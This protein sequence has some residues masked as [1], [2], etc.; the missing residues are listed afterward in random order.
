MRR[1]ALNFRK[2]V[3][4]VIGLPNLF[5]GGVAAS[6]STASALATKLG[7]SESDIS[8]F[9][10]SGNDVEA[11][12]EIDYVLPEDCFLDSTQITSFVDLQHCKGI[13]YRSLYQCINLQKVEIVNCLYVANFAIRRSTALTEILLQSC[14][15]VQGTRAF[16][17]L[18]N[19][20]FCYLPVV[21]SLG[22]TVGNDNVFQFSKTSAKILINK[23]L[24]TSN[25]GA[26]DGDLVSMSN[27]VYIDNY[28]PPDAISDLTV[29][30]KY[31]TALQ[32]N[33]TPPASVNTV[34]FYQV[35]IN[36]FYHSD[37]GSPGD[38]IFGLSPN[39]AYSD[40]TVKAVDALYNKSS[41]SNSVSATTTSSYIDDGAV[42]IFSFRR[43]RSSA[44]YAAKISRSSD[45]AE[46]DV[47]LPAENGNFIS[48]S[49]MVSSGGTLGSWVGANDAV[50]KTVYGQKG[51]KN[52]S[53][54]NAD[55]KLVIAGVLNTINGKPAIV[56]NTTTGHGLEAL[57]V[58]A[59]SP[60]TDASIFAVIRNNDT[61]VTNRAVGFGNYA[62][63][64]I[65]SKT[66]WNC[67]ADNSLRFDGAAINTPLVTAAVGNKIRSSF[68]NGDTYSDYINGVQNIVPTVLSGTSIVDDFYVG[69]HN[70][71][72]FYFSEAIVFLSDESA[73]RVLIENEINAAY[74]IY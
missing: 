3:S 17:V 26:P 11:S 4:P 40:I 22:E 30:T 73:D 5:I 10:V 47:L 51:F 19:L 38:F 63:D 31:A 67:A 15:N 48:M 70:T 50:V 43:R 42:E 25:S 65:A 8:L 29:G 45:N 24:E 53:Y 27:V 32:L 69:I 6:I 55:Y 23:F 39:S 74:S 41:F 12:I 64:G 68:K 66:H 37:L 44:V 1:R 57:G 28:T 21:T 9:Q 13:E 46:T 56:G 72:N 18:S 52:L 60:L 61:V 33:F 34:E 54:T 2:H 14:T 36:G 71:Q 20:D 62:K 58:N 59:G 7:I 49:S 16:S 35:Y